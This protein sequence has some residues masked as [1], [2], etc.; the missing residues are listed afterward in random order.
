M[1]VRGPANDEEI[2]RFLADL[3][4]PGL[5]DVHVHF[6][7]EPMLTKVWAYFDRAEKSYGFPWPIRYRLPEAD[8]LARLRGFGV[9]A[10]PALSYPHKP[11]MAPWLNQWSADCPPRVPGPPP[12]A[13]LS[14]EPDAGACVC[15][16]LQD[17]ARLFKVHLQVGRFS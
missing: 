11:G 1:P 12:R 2:P 5:A 7:P 6:L 3:G 17:G 10:I 13:P 8:R 14:P 16:A 9:R 4:L 15:Q